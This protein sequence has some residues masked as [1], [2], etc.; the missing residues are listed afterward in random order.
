VAQNKMSTSDHSSELNVLSQVDLPLNLLTLYLRG[1]GHA[2]SK[3]HVDLFHLL[4]MSGD[5]PG[6]V[7]PIGAPG[8]P[9]LVV[10]TSS[11]DSEKFCTLS[12]HVLRCDG[13]RITSLC[14]QG[15]RKSSSLFDLRTAA[16]SFHGIRDP[17]DLLGQ[18][19]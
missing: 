5:W 9:V 11:Y 2:T 17:C 1:D 7:C 15:N 6:D 12:D 8:P 14:Y 3:D 19:C 18:S 13:S 4:I 10:V 16:G